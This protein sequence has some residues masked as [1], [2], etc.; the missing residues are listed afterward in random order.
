[1]DLNEL[2]FKKRTPGEYELQWALREHGYYVDDVSSDPAY[3]I[4]DID[5]LIEP[6][7]PLIGEDVVTSIEVKWDSRIAVTGN[8]F[9]ELENPRSKGGMGWFEFCKAD[10]LAYGDARNRIFYFIKMND[11]KNYIYESKKDLRA[12]STWDGSYGYIIPLNNISALIA[13]TMKV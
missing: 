11:L 3:W 7:F 6:I 8:L 9:I 10:Y 1:M 4:Q 13:G 12:R 2:L 5:L